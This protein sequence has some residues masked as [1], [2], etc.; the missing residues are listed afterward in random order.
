MHKVLLVDDNLD[1]LES[2]GE[3][4]SNRYAVILA[5]DGEKA[6][7]ILGRERVDVV[8]LDLVMPGLDGTAVLREMRAQNLRV[9]VIIISAHVDP[10]HAA[11]LN[12][13]NDSLR[14]PFSVAELEERIERILGQR[15]GEGSESPDDSGTPSLRT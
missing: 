13:A 9:P 4:L 7:E 1:L 6:V 14:K 11:L 2:L 10:T 8:V 5:S 3:L 12:L 15:S